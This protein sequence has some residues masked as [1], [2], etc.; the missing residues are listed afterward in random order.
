MD[1]AIKTMK[2]KSSNT[3]V[4]YVQDRSKNEQFVVLRFNS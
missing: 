1:N 4:L 2:E 3:I